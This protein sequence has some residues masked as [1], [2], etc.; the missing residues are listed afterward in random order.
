MGRRQGL[1]AI[2]SA[3]RRRWALCL[4][5]AVP[6]ALVVAIYARTAPAQYDGQT[7][8]AFSPR[9]S[10]S[11]GAD[12]M[13]VVLPRYVSLL[14]AQA[15]VDNVARETGVDPAVVDGASVVVA[16][17]TANL[18]IVVRDTDPQQAAKAANALAATALLANDKDNLLQAQQV[19]PALPPVKPAAPPRSLLTLAG[20]LAG[21]IVGL[22]VA[23]LAERGRPRIEDEQDVRDADAP[24]VLG[25]IPTSLTLARGRSAAVTDPHIA[26]AV[27]AVLARTERA[28]RPAD[29]PVLG[30]TSPPGAHGRTTTTL[31]L[32]AAAARQN[33]SVIVLDAD[34][35][36]RGL[37]DETWSA[38]A[39]TADL[40]ALLTGRATLDDCLAPGPV[41]GVSVVR[42]ASGPD[43][44]DLLARGRPGLLR[45]LG[46]RADLV[47]VDCPP[48]DDDDG[49]AL[50]VHLPA[51]VLVVR[52]GTSST[53]LAQTAV[54]LQGLGPRALGVALNRTETKGHSGPRRG[55]RLLRRIVPDPA[56]LVRESA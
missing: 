29:V 2:L 18:L 49:Q 15:T 12:V 52:S 34:L 21:L 28:A 32:A 51:V 5:V 8:V 54:L 42:A 4:I 10:A 22:T 50:I 11:I 9:P 37:S 13:R 20:L 27:R 36:R 40:T 23:V 1:P 3:I 38:P 24:D 41:A 17:D 14:K 53:A 19:A 56:R 47:I 16:T 6:L 55:T 30:V 31:A 45:E 44:L 48:V 46:E 35:T 43:A 33:R 39:G 7:T 26:S 25:R